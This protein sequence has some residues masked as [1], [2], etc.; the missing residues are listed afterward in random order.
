MAAASLLFSGCGGGGGAGAGSVLPAAGP[1]ATTAPSTTSVT[2]NI[3]ADPNGGMIAGISDALIVGGINSNV[4]PVSITVGLNSTATTASVGHHRGPSTTRSSSATLRMTQVAATTQVWQ[5]GPSN[6]DMLRAVLA[7]LQRSETSATSGARRSVQSLPTAVGSQTQIWVQNF[8]PGVAG[9]TFEQVPATLAIQTA[10]ASVWVQ[11]SLDL[12]TNTSALSTIA[13][14]IENAMASDNAHFGTSTW[15]GS[16]ASLSK[17]YG[18]CDANGNRNGGS[19]PEFIVPTDPHVNFVYVDP[20]EI[21]VGGYMDADSLLPEDVIRCTQA[22]NGT[23]HSNESPTIVLAYYGD[24]RGMNYV[25]DEDSIVHPAHEYQHLI[26]IVH[27]AILQST[28]AYEDA[29]LNEGLSMMAQDFAIAAATS[30][31]EPLDGENLYRSSAYLAA[32]QNYSVAGFAGL[33][34]PGNTLFN[35]SIC[36]GPAWLFERYLYDRFGGDAYVH[37]MEA[38]SSTSWGELGSVTGANPQQLLHDFALAVGSSNTPAA[39]APYQFASLNLHA[40]YTDQLGNVYALTGPAPLASLTSGSSQSYNVLLGAYVYF[41]LP[42]SASSA[43]ASLNEAAS[44]FDL[45]GA[46]IAY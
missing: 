7:T 29:L 3:P 39:V 19:S 31:V 9:T 44:S 37:A 18:T 13:S 45:N 20:S 42:G 22:N 2:L 27:H 32:T 30:G 28:P 17:Q 46:V 10:H 11:N 6:S 33:Q 16:A 41:A 26:N 24:S 40:T 35:C 25:L 4:A 12:L 1:L 38:G 15:D 36:Y 8:V 21:S 23:Y 14:N 5:D 34:S 43:S